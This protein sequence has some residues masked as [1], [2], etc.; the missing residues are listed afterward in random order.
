MWFRT[1]VVAVVGALLAGSSL[2]AQQPAQIGESLR[3][4]VSGPV[5]LQAALAREGVIG[6]HAVCKSQINF[7]LR[8]ANLGR[9]APLA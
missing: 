3:V 4:Q 7:D 8:A 9:S 1:L 6:D 5:G 2:I